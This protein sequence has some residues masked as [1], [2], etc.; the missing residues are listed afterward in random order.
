MGYLGELTSEI[1]DFLFVCV[2]A[3]VRV[4]AFVR[5]RRAVESLL[6]VFLANRMPP[7]VVGL[8]DYN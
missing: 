4:Y 8:L 7:A 3:S 6:R 5:V 1:Y 2:C